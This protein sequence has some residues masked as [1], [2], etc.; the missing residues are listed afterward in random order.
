MNIKR[1]FVL[2]VIGTM[3]CLSEASFC[4]PVIEV[5][6][7]D[8]QFTIFNRGDEDLNWRATV[9][10]TG[11][12]NERAPLGENA[13]ALLANFNKDV[14]QH[15]TAA[16][17]DPVNEWIWVT[18]TTDATAIAYTF[19][20]EYQNFSEARRIGAGE[21]IDG[22]WA[23]GLLYLPPYNSNV[24]N[25]YNSA[26][27][28]IG[29]VEMAFPI[30]GI[31]A[32]D[33]RDR[34]FLMS[35]DDTLIHVFRL[36]GDGSVG[37]EIGVIENH[38]E[39]HDN[40]VSF[41]I[42]WVY[43]H[44]EGNLWMISPHSGGVHE[45]YVDTGTWQC[46]EEVQNFVVFQ[47]GDEPPE[48]SI[49]HDGHNLWVGGFL[50][51]DVRIYDDGIREFYWLT[52]EPKSGVVQ[53]EQNQEANVIFDDDGLIGGDY[54]A[55]IHIESNDPATPEYDLPVSFFIIG[56]PDLVVEWS[57]TTGFPNIIDFNMRFDDINVEEPYSFQFIVRNKGTDDLEIFEI[58]TRSQF[59]SIDFRDG[60]ILAPGY[61]QEVELVFRTEEEGEFNEFLTLV[62]NDPDGEDGLNFPIHAS[63]LPPP[64]ITIDP[65]EI[66]C[67]LGWRELGELVV[68]ISNDGESALRWRGELTGM[69]DNVRLTIIEPPV[70]V[71][72]AGADQ[73]IILVAEFVE[74]DSLPS[75]FDLTF[76]SN[77]PETPEKIVHIVVQTLGVQEMGATLP[78]TTR[79][80]S[81]YPNPFNSSTTITFGLNKSAPMR[82][83]VYGVDGRLVEDLVKGR[84]AY[85]P[86]YHKIVWNAAGV[87]AG[88][89][90]VRFEAGEGVVQEQWVRLVK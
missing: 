76:F 88:S 36:S 60:V 33:Q 32:D 20:N 28:N 65:E 48:T 63:T 2:V 62:S 14:N 38:L 9:E 23:N 82:L 15:V 70:G 90:L 50:E 53:P 83:A 17:W 3:L 80:L 27:Q 43:K 24:L 18:Y 79:L 84:D 69:Q 51:D 58:T 81:L 71:I 37:R 45:I 31:A 7:E 40:D 56:T 61:W 21:C 5:V 52:I 39:F 85:P 74:T 68:N 29:A 67:E 89:Y 47:G 78:T 55:T 16:A 4:W 41:G 35:A 73:D 11:E 86:G 57:D 8:N 22:A 46:V 19:D 6:F 87:P 30:V 25:R 72:A 12:P 1:F 49:G 10:I 13:G 26:G 75:E 44:F 59:F 64:I 42:E 54:S 66:A 77:D 34:L